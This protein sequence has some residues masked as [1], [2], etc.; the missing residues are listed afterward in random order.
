MRNLEERGLE[1]S[2][3]TFLKGISAV[4][5]TALAAGLNLAGTSAALP[6]AARGAQ[7]AEKTKLSSNHG[8]PRPNGF[9]GRAQN[10]SHPFTPRRKRASGKAL[11]F[12]RSRCAADASRAMLSTSCCKVAL[13][14]AIFAFL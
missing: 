3:R 9:T 1:N 12:A 11:T 14:T 6:A 5:L 8:R 10:A 2:R 13:L 7:S 4:P